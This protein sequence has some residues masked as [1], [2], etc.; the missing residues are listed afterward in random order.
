MDAD[1]I[2]QQTLRKYSQCS[3][4]SDEGCIETAG[5]GRPGILFKTDY[6]RPSLFRFEWRSWH[7]FFGRIAPEYYNVIG[8][9]ERGAYEFYD[10][11]FGLGLSF[12]RRCKTLAL[13]I[14]GATGISQGA[15]YLVSSLVMPLVVL[16]DRKETLTLYDAEFL[17]VEPGSFGGCYHIRCNQREDFVHEFWIDRDDFSLRKILTEFSTTKEKE[18]ASLLLKTAALLCPR[19]CTEYVFNKAVFNQPIAESVFLCEK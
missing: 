5:F 12:K 4:Y 2:V 6:V 18:S 17:P 16:R 14:A 15:A 10:W 1:S 11:S 7:P 8:A 3:T 19:I 9:D 13:A